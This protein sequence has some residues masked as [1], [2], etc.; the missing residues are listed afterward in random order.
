[1]KGWI[2][3]ELPTKKYIKA[4]IISQIGEKPRMDTRHKIGSKLHDLLQHKTNERKT[5]FSQ[6][7]NCTIRIYI[8]LH[9]FKNRGAYLNETNIKNF[10]Q[11]VENDLKDKF[12]F[13]MDLFI[14]MLP[15]FEANLPE[16]RKKLG[17]DIE[18]WSDDSMR[19]DY[20][21]YRKA[22][23]KPLLYNK[24]STRTVPSEIST[25]FPF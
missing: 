6:R 21:R 12:Y 2:P 4:Y 9:I 16:V 13:L 10:N 19:K 23:G 17:I 8:S 15:S 11:F 22:I 18:A 1:M 7:Y 25:C 20:Y 5:E 3:V 24:N 14:E